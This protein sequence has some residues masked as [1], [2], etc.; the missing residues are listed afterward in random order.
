VVAAILAV[1]LVA[2]D[3]GGELA[4]AQPTPPDGA[5]GGRSNIDSGAHPEDASHGDDADAGGGIEPL[6][7]GGPPEPGVLSLRR[8]NST[9]YDN[10]VRDLLGTTLQPA[11]DFPADDLLYGF[12]NIGSAL[13]ISTLLMEKY[14]QAAEQLV[15]DLF[16]RSDETVYADIITCDVADGGKGCAEEI[17]VQFARR[18]WR[19]PVVASE[20]APYAA[21]LD[22]S[23]TPEEGLRL[24]LQGV[25]LSSNFIFR[26]ESDPDPQ[27][28][29]P[30]ALT[31]PE[32]ASRLS[33]LLWNTMPD[34]ELFD[35]AARG[36]LASD[37]GL[38][39][40]LERM[41]IDP[42]VGAFVTDMAGLWLQARNLP[43]QARDTNVFPQWN[44]ALR[45]SMRGETE[46]FLWELFRG[47]RPIT[48]LLT[49]DFAMLNEP[50]A[51]LYGIEGV[52]GNLYQ[53]V[54]LSG[55]EQRRGLL[56]QASFLT[57]TS[58][59]QRT[60]PVSRGK[61]VLEQLLCSP[62]PPPPPEVNPNLD[63]PNFTGLSLRERLELHQ[64]QGSTCM[65]CHGWMDPIGLGLEH[66]DAIGAFRT[67]DEYGIIDASGEL[68]GSPAQPFDG[69]LELSELLI[70]DPRFERCV[71]QQIATY[72]LG[73][74]P[75]GAW[76]DAIVAQS[77]SA[78]DRSLKSILRALVMSGAFRTR[79]AGEVQP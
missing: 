18:A 46:S 56:T 25:L 10:T 69:A 70:Q 26:V 33:Y 32:L 4:S 12:D 78:G 6:A 8:L 53:R 76:L 13:S 27:V 20:L 42:K 7:D 40:Q 34:A 64:Q 52:S 63:S 11:A 44:S 22:E 59:P 14:E 73:E 65:A 16:A 15:T 55:N 19:R 31:G 30:H 48:E 50:V 77:S 23:A 66:Y 62:P 74:R 60:S 79:R 17:L 24:A 28:A 47:D 51:V 2:C 71:A 37:G 36:D 43:E 68:P 29:T 35:A 9:Q 49:A 61:W 39:N 75:T 1:G 72:G 21:L 3:P 45:Q 38:T 58:H 5:V 54:D 67:E 41:L 57:V